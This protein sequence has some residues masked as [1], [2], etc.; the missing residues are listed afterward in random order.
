MLIRA[1]VLCLLSAIPGVQVEAGE[2]TSDELILPASPHRTSPVQPSPR[3][4]GSVA[5]KAVIYIVLIGGG[6]YV[7]WRLSGRKFSR[8]GGLGK[9]AEINICETRMLGNR[10]H[11]VLVECDGR[12][13]LLGVGPGTI[14]HLCFLDDG[15]GKLDT[16]SFAATLESRSEKSDR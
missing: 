7:Y 11:L 4:T 16:P 1:L 2:A 6:L 8:R 5:T 14:S 3:T 10:Q 9:K 13:L 12:R 15:L